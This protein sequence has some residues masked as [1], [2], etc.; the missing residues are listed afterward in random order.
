MRKY[1]LT[2]TNELGYVQRTIYTSL[3]EAT[4]F[5]RKYAMEGVWCQLE[6]LEGGAL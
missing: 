3:S 4:F 6:V 2:Y 1:V 5:F